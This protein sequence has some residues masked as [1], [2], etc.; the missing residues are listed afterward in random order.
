MYWARSVG[1]VKVEQ[2]ALCVEQFRVLL[3]VGPF[4]KFLRLGARDGVP[5]LALDS[6][7]RLVESLLERLPLHLCG[8]STL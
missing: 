3:G 2:R 6:V 7:E 1:V 4:P 8:G 5:A